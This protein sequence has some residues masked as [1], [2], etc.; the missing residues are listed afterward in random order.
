MQGAYMSRHDDRIAAKA[1]WESLQRS[2][3]LVRGSP[4]WTQAGIV[5]SEN[6]DGPAARPSDLKSSKQDAEVRRTQEARPATVV[7]EAVRK[8][9]ARHQDVPALIN[10]LEKKGVPAEATREAV[11]ALIDTGV[12]TFD[13][14]MQLKV[15]R[16][17][18]RPARNRCENEKDTEMAR[19]LLALAMKFKT[20]ETP[21][22]PWPRQRTEIADWLTAL[23]A[24]R[25]RTV[26]NR[27]ELL[28]ELAALTTRF[29]QGV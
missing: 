13:K 29:G 21:M 10:A 15:V 26:Y 22:P 4:A 12:L 23:E 25:L 27:Q 28:I 24:R 17:S 8:M 20:L 9:V 11:R 3:E 2:V 6:F 1:F 16:R 14:G 7:E 18:K 5:L 19:A